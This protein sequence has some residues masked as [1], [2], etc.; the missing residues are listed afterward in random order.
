MVERGI[1]Y[2]DDRVELLAGILIAAEPQSTY[3][4]GPL[5][6]LAERFMRGVDPQAWMV[7][8]QMAVAVDEYSEPEPDLAVVP[9]SEATRRD[10]HPQRAVLV[11]EVA[12]TTLRLDLGAKRKLYAAAGIPEYWVVDVPRHRLLI[13]TQPT[14]SDG[15]YQSAR[16]LGPEDTAVALAFPEVPIRI[17]DLF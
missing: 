17:A 12:N 15:S 10:S 1:L 16:E 4:N 6:L 11:V 14:V 7:R 2:E 13:F 5:Q 3:H 9:R 8:I